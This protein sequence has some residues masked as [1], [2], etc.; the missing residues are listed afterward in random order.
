VEVN[1]KGVKMKVVSRLLVFSG[2]FVTLGGI[3]QLL[4]LVQWVSFVGG[5]G[6]LGIGLVMMLAGVLLIATE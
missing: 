4:G 6:W 5:M 3:L 1:L 2:N